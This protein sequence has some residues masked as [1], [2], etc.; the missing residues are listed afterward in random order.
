MP[1]VFADAKYSCFYIRVLIASPG[2]NG[3]QGEPS[4][5]VG[6]VRACCLS[7]MG[8]QANDSIE[9]V[10]FGYERMMP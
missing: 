6:P 5:L 7:G 4:A 1:Y 3:A 8:P 10:R 2:V 9:S